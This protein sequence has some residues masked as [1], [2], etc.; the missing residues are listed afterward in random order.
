[1]GNRTNY[2]N[3]PYKD[4]TNTL[5]DHNTVTKVVSIYCK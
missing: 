4:P 5:Q 1:M 3:T 2:K